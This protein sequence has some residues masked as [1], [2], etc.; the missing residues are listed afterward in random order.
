MLGVRVPPGLPFIMSKKVSLFKRISN[1]LKEVKVE[2]IHRTSW[3]TKKRLIASFVTILIFI[4]FW[5]VY[6][7]IL[8]SIFAY[9]LRLVITI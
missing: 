7:G 2:F 8:D 4:A 3:P 1:F 5:A 6:I 9:L